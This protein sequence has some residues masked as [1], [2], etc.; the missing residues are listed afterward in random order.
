MQDCFTLPVCLNAPILSRGPYHNIYFLSLVRSYLR[1][2]GG[3]NE[4]ISCQFFCLH[5]SERKTSTWPGKTLMCVGVCV[6]MC[7]QRHALNYLWNLLLWACLCSSLS[8]HAIV[9]C[10]YK[11][12]VYGWPCLTSPSPRLSTMYY[13]VDTKHTLSVLIP[14]S[15]VTRWL[16]MWYYTGRKQLQMS[17]Y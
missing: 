2:T 10:I 6:A 4:F 16:I 12:L 1:S 3:A 11:K 5:F 17:F 13:V 14:H 7:V 15:K 8:L 9:F